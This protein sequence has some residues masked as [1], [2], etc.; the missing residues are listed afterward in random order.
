MSILFGPR[1]KKSYKVE[2]KDI[3]NY[4][5]ERGPHVET[6]IEGLT[7]K[8]FKLGNRSCRK[9][10]DNIAV[11]YDIVGLNGA[12]ITIYFGPIEG[13]EKY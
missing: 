2:L 3:S 13:H 8:E 10:R 4:K 5:N 1:M 6:P 11:M 7:G 12:H 9:I